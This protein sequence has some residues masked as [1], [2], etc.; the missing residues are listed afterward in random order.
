MRLTGL[1]R[2]KMVASGTRVIRWLLKHLSTSS[3][4]PQ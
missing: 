1:R 4:T 2:S 3:A